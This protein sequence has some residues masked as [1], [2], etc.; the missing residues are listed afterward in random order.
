MHDYYNHDY[1]VSILAAD[2]LDSPFPSDVNVRVRCDPQPAAGIALQGWSHSH[3]GTERAA[4][5][6]NT[7]AAKYSVS[8]TTLSIRNVSASD[9]GL[10]RCLYATGNHRRLCIYVYGKSVHL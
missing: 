9:E 8:G 6:I 3:D 4:V 1:F 2:Y 5:G 10:Y 7:S